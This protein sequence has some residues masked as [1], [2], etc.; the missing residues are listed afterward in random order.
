MYSK[1]ALKDEPYFAEIS[2]HEG[3]GGSIDGLQI[4]TLLMIYYPSFCSSSEGGE[5]S[6]AYGHRERCLDAFLE[7]AAK[8]PD[9]LD[10]WIKVLPKP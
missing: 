10:R 6:N 4:V 5:P 9:Q 2:W 7:Y 1:S 3:Q 8:E